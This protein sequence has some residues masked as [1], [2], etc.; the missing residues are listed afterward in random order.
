MPFLKGIRKSNFLG[1]FIEFRLS[2]PGPSASRSAYIMKKLI[3][4][5]LLFLF[6]CGNSGLPEGSF[7]LEFDESVWKSPKGLELDENNITLR[8]KMLGDLVNNRSNRKRKR[9]RC[10]YAG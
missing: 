9:T 6:G 8:Q 5:S 2:F 4:I 10:R 7:E 3:I 1:F